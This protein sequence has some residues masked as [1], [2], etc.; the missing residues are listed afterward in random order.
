MSK[1]KQIKVDEGKEK[2]VEIPPP[3]VATCD[4]AVLIDTVHTGLP[5]GPLSACPLAAP[6]PKWSLLPTWPLRLALFSVMMR[7]F[8]Q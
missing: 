5:H 2:S 7:S 1:F 6:K 4:R 8:S 3:R